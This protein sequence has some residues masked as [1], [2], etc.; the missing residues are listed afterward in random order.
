M[1]K[2]RKIP[3][4]IIYFLIIVMRPMLGPSHVCIYPVTCTNY[5]REQLQTKSLFIAIPLIVLRVLSCNPITAIIM[6]VK[7]KLQK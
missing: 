2:L 7:H 6:R 5:A 4:K 3:G 1:K